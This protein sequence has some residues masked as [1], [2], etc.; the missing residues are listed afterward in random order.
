MN[1]LGGRKFILALLSLG[2]MIM[3]FIVMLIKGFLTA[4]KCMQFITY[5]PI[6]MTIFVGGNVLEKQINKGGKNT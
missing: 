3:V 2:F 6:V 4:D 1:K 5:V